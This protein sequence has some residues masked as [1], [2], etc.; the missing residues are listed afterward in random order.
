MAGSAASQELRRTPF[1]ARHTALGAKMIPFAGFEMPVH[2]PSGITA[3][4]HAVRQRCGLFDVS[5]MGE[6][7]VTG[8]GAVD[9]VNF[10]ATN[11]VGALK[12][13]QAHYSMLLN[14]R[15]TIVDDCLV[16]CLGDRVMMVVNASNRERDFTHISQHLERFECIL[17]DVSDDTALLALQ[18]PDAERV[19]A[20]LTSI[21]LAGI[22]YYH[23]EEGE[24]S[25]IPAIISRTGYTGEDG[26]ELYFSPE[27]AGSVWDA[28]LAGGDVTPAGLGARDTLRLEAGMALYGNELDEEINPYEANL[29]WTVKPKK[30]EFVGR[31]ALLSAKERGVKRKLVGLTTDER[32]FPRPGYPIYYRGERSGEIRSGT[33]SPTL[34][35]PIA[36]A[37]LPAE[38]AAPG[39]PVAIEI[40]GRRVDARVVRLPFY[41]RPERG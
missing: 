32:A 7:E 27:H 24:V 10:V 31:E 13:G 34:G 16:Y 25:G 26:F 20:P 2:Y 23:F 35:I 14:D 37:Y 40:R 39:E 4:H 18:G 36:T 12:L 19:L 3:E 9:F 29:G 5:H 38:G 41:R 15:G 21:E 17:H 33:M 8:R 6:F 30:G 28:L 1:H 22:A 11:D